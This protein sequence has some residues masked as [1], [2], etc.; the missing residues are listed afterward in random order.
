MD[1]LQLPLNSQVYELLTLLMDWISDQHLSKIKIQEEREDTHK[2]MATQTSKK[3]CTQER[4]MKVKGFG[5]FACVNTFLD[6]W[7]VFKWFWDYNRSACFIYALDAVI[8]TKSLLISQYSFQQWDIIDNLSFVK[9]TD[10]FQGKV[11]C[12]VSTWEFQ[13]FIS[14]HFCQLIICVVL[15]VILYII[16]FF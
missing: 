13:H 6:L 16:P 3:S 9:H 4:C 12:S 1:V 7:G 14:S 5:L 8:K 11:W 10:T 2:F 15:C